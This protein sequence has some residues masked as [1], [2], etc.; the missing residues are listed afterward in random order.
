MI[1]PQPQEA[2]NRMPKEHFSLQTQHD[3]G[4]NYAYQLLFITSPKLSL[5]NW[6]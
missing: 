1:R 2:T 6:A 3:N 5:K 4:H